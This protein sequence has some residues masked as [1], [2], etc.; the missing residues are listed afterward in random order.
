M[1]TPVP[2]SA[3]VLAAGDISCGD[4]GYTSTAPGRCQDRATSDLVLSLQSDKV[5]AIGDQVN[6]YGRVSEFMGVFEPSWGRFKSKILPIPGN[7]EYLEDRTAKAYFDY[8]NGAGAATGVAGE[9]TKGYYSFDLGAWHVVALNSN[10]DK[11]DCAAQA[12]WLRT[13]LALHPSYCT[14]AYFHHPL[15]AAPPLDPEGRV[16]HFWQALYDFGADVILNAHLHNYQR[17][18]LMNPSGAL[19]STR[20]IREF[21]V[22]TGG[23]SHYRFTGTAPNSEAANDNSYGVLEL[24]LKPTSYSW[25]FVPVPGGTFTDSGEAQCH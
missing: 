12:V 2:A 21:I 17:F 24:N 9:R 23:Y 20:G 4:A 8:F 15:F 13:D 18:A 5:L 19:D 22:G 14:L 11:V 10:C 1:P 6:G 25:R 3:V 7:H 16:V